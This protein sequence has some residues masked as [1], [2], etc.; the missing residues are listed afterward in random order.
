[1]EQNWVVTA[2]RADFQAIAQ[3]FGIDP[4]TA[5][6][7]R[8]RDVITEE[9]IRR[10]LHGGTADLYDP[11]KMKGIPEA[12]DI[13]LDEIRSGGQIRVIGDYDIDGV[14]ASFIL[15]TGIRKLQTY[16]C[17]QDDKSRDVQRSKA[18]EA[19]ADVRIPD[20]IRDGYGMNPSL[21]QQAIDDGR[22]LILTCDNGISAGD[23][24]ALAKNAGLRVIVTDHHEIPFIE[25][26]MTGSEEVITDST[27]KTAKGGN[28]SAPGV[29]EKKKIWQ[30]PPA[31]VVIDPKQEDCAYPFKGL[32]G[33]A[34]A[35][36]LIQE[37]YRKA[38]MQETEAEEFLDVVGIATVGDVMDLCDE[39]RILVKEGLKRL[40]WTGRPGL[41]ELIA[42]N[43]LEKEQID[44]YH[45]GFVLGPCLNAG[46]RLDTALRA[47]ALL[48]AETRQEAAATAAELIALNARRKELTAQGVEQAVQI[49]DHSEI[50]KD[51]V[52]VVFL[53]ECHE[54]LA[55]IIAGR[56]REH[57][58]KP[59]FVLTRGEDGVKGSGRSI[60]AYSMYEELCKCRELLTRFGGHPMAAGLSLPEDQVDN[61]RERI[62]A[63]CSLTEN[64]LCPK[65]TIDVPM[66]VSYLRMDLVR[67]FELLRPFG[68]G[69]PRPLFA[70]KDMQ[71]LSARV[72]GKKRNVLKM[73]MADPA[74][75]TIDAV[76]FGEADTMAQYIQEHRKLDIVYY[77]GSDTWQ[78][79][80]KLQ[81]TVQA[82]R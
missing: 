25:T 43:G 46:G 12:A 7:I 64:D 3:R 19:D 57:Y 11:E 26:E 40:H 49:V 51:R 58:G 13:L 50:R 68:K 76:Y 32:C 30:I 54:S 63:A 28:G 52:L 8:N 60:E 36:K 37:L 39:N 15:L 81:I 71:V 35:W 79:R 4:V 44:V 9:E 65:I 14:C 66:P 21:V 62:N 16:L 33:A 55:G 73:R 67:E 6:L 56:L 34:V 29:T 47:L 1:M 27:G 48:C 61:F 69:N 23:A 24:V 41:L 82:Y 45:I 78:G 31:D 18:Y 70:Q 10:F 17:T 42:Q 75:R 74:G 2:K 38:G 53:P 5:R 20:R 59:S 22:T 80:Q 72:F 77:P